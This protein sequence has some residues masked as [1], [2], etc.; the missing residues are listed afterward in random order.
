MKP[1]SLSSKQQQAS[2]FSSQAF[3]NITLTLSAA[4]E[5]GKT[6]VLTTLRSLGLNLSLL[7]SANVSN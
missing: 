3:V 5:V 7:L 4:S 2:K 6:A 1:L